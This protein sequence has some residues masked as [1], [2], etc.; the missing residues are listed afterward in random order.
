MSLPERVS[1]VIAIGRVA[2]T[3]RIP[4]TPK[5]PRGPFGKRRDGH[6]ELVTAA[7]ATAAAPAAPGGRRRHEPAVA[8]QAEDGQLARDVGALACGAGNLRRGAMD[9]RFE[10][11][12]A[13]AT[14]VLV[15]RHAYSPPRCT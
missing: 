15:D 3:A 10:V 1:S 12:P 13:A 2:R 14:P 11:V 5:G 9:V 7:A 4:S 6:T 8:L